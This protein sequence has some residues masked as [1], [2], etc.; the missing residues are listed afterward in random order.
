AATNTSKTLRTASEV[1][2]G[3]TALLFL[4]VMGFILKHRVLRP[5]VRLSDVVHRLA[6]QDYGV[7]TPNF[8]QVDEIGDMAQAI[9]IFREN[10]LARQRLEKERDADW[11][12]REL[13][14]RMTQ[15][16][17]GCENVSDVIEVAELFAPNI[18]P[19][20]A[21]RLYILDRNPWEMRC[22]AE[23]LSPQGEKNAFHPDQCWAIRRGQ[24]HPPVNGEPD[25]GCQH[26]P[27]SQKDSSLCVPLIAQGEAIGLLSFQNIT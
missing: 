19:G 23:W 13:L 1:M 4:F 7:E 15:R 14:A 8:N 6:S 21:G 25:I 24:S 2:V 5:V 26:L 20:I 11:A 27:E 12:I 22:A 10:G 18:A 16:L 3:L 17:Q 9:R